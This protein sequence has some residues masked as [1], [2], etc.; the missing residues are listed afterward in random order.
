MAL[1][2]GVNLKALLKSPLMTLICSAN[3]K[4]SMSKTHIQHGTRVRVWKHPT[5]SLRFK[6]HV[7]QSIKSHVF[8]TIESRV[9]TKIES[10]A[11][12]H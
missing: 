12:L 9:S 3:L 11:Q 10:R 7:F 8:I 4:S 5:R 1:I 2:S 6:S